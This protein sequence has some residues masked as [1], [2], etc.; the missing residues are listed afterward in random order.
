MRSQSGF[1]D[2]EKTA[3]SPDPPGRHAVSLVEIS[4]RSGATVRN[5]TAD[6][7]VRRVCIDELRAIRAMLIG[8]I[9]SAAA[10]HAHQ[11]SVVTAGL[12]RPA[13]PNP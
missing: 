11:R 13:R 4:M 1:D 12:S 7:V 5:G 3:D 2:V 8:S 10:T 9:T 6:T